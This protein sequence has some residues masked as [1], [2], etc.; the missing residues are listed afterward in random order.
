MNWLDFTEFLRSFVAPRK[1]KVLVPQSRFS[2]ENATEHNLTLFAYLTLLYT[3]QC[4]LF[5][6][7]C[8]SQG[9]CW[10]EPTEQPLLNHCVTP[11]G[12][13]AS[14]RLSLNGASSVRACAT[15][16]HSCAA[17]KRQK[18]KVWKWFVNVLLRRLLNSNPWSWWPGSFATWA[19]KCVFFLEQ[20]LMY[21]YVSE[22]TPLLR[23]SCFSVL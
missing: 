14:V 7:A 15:T 6:L 10:Q 12:R 21:V 3:L 4:V 11:A 1:K 5:S 8:A 19:C 23:S 9:M 13:E 2:C 17:S 20:V 18:S 16:R 22:G